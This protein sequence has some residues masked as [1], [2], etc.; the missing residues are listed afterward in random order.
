MTAQ[1]VLDRVEELGILDPKIIAELRKQVLESKY[2]V[3]PEA[4]VKVL[5]D[6]GHLT[7]Y[8]ARK[9]VADVTAEEQAAAIPVSPIPKSG[10]ASPAKTSRPPVDEDDL[11]MLDSPS[12]VVK[13]QPVPDEEEEI[14]DLE[15]ALPP[16]GP[17]KATVKPISTKSASPTG[18]P[19]PPE[20]RPAEKKTSPP[21]SAQPDDDVV[22]L[23][24]ITPAPKKQVAAKPT[25]S[26]QPFTLE[27]TAPRPVAPQP[28]PL[29][30]V[31]L[32]PIAPVTLQ[33]LAPQALQPLTPQGLQPLAP[34]VM[35]PIAPP[36]LQPLGG[37]PLAPI[38][39]GGDALFG[40]GGMDGFGAP[41][42][43][44]APEEPEKPKRAKKE[45]GRWDS[46]LMLLGGGGLGVLVIAFVGLFFAL[47]RGSSTEILDQANKAYQS[48]SYTQ[49]ADLYRKYV[50]KFPT[51]QNVS[52][53]RV[54]VGM[55][56]LRQA[57]DGA[58]DMRS[59]LK[60]ANEVL[61]TIE[62]EERFD[63]ARSELESILP[64]IADAFA[65]Q[66]KSSAEVSRMKPLV[67]N[68]HEAMKLVNNA[69]Y[70]PT[71]KRKAH[72]TK[73]DSILEK[74]RTVE[75]TINQ[76]QALAEAL[77]ALKEKLESGDIPSAYQVRQ[78]L[79][80]NYP[81]LEQHSEVVQATLS[82]AQREAQLVVTT[83]INKAGQTDDPNRAPHPQIVL[84]NRSGDTLTVPANSL[85]YQLIRGA[86]YAID[87]ATGQVRWRRHVGYE[88]RIL[89]LPLSPGGDVIVA[90][91]RYHEILRLEA[92]T[93]KAI[94]RQTFDQPF[95]MSHTLLDGFIFVST[96][97]G[98]IFRVNSEGGEVTH[99]A[100]LPQ[101][102]S[103]APAV[104][105]RRKL[106]YQL[107]E[108][109][110][111]HVLAG[112]TSS[113]EPLASKECYYLGHRRGTIAVPPSVVLG[114]AFIYENIA[115]DQ[116]QIHVLARNEENVLQPVVA[117]IPRRG[118]IVVS[119]AQASKRLVVIGDL[120]DTLVIEVEPANTAKAVNL[121]A[122]MVGGQS[123]PTLSYAA[124]DGARLLIAD[125]RLAEFDVLTT[126][127]EL[128]RK[129]S[130][131]DRDVF[132]GP[133][134]LIDRNLI[135][136]RKRFGSQSVT[137]TGANLAG[138]GTWQLEL[139]APIAAAFANPEQREFA[140][141]TSDG[142]LFEV[143]AEQLRQGV[144]DK[145]SAR[146]SGASAKTYRPCGALPAGGHLF[147]E[148]AGSD[149]LIYIPSA[150][151]HLTQ[152]HTQTPDAIQ[153]RIVPFAGGV[154]APLSSGS[155]WLLDV[156]SG[157]PLS[158]T[159]PLQPELAPGAKVE[160]LAPVIIDERQFIVVDRSRRKL[161][162]ARREEKP[163][164]Y[165]AETRNIDLDY[166][167]VSIA[168][169]GGLVLIVARGQ[170][171]DEVLAY[172]P[173]NL[174]VSQKW[175]IDGRV[176]P[177][178]LETA[179]GA[180]FC[181]AAGEFW[182]FSDKAALAWKAIIPDGELLVGPPTS[183]GSDWLVVATSGK[184]YSLN[185][186]SGDPTLMGSAR[187]PLAGQA[188][189]FG[190]RLVVGG[191]DGSLHVLPLKAEAP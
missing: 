188:Q 109:S 9:L 134:Q 146:A 170:T 157:K 123:Q 150:D 180:I 64:D 133:L 7:T 13:A 6:K 116:S 130:S 56:R 66:A 5:V 94:W 86:V 173:V 55:S 39:M 162:L 118:R 163:K 142:N 45:R 49:A 152:V 29:Q 51:E 136:V 30:P 44:L 48:G 23:E 187:E 149:W 78:Q 16:S 111:L 172:N 175:P 62:G 129:L 70:I 121:V 167:P 46:A 54:R 102:L 169:V 112:D 75:R 3:T 177:R 137:V 38:G 124:I 185:G 1:K 147:L 68:A 10:P 164:P 145:P 24:P 59:A 168:A 122:S 88:T 138:K 26:Q 81:P 115:V 135:H 65:T 37:Q 107:L 114:H 131:F 96:Q 15:A 105:T 34:Q 36:M 127:Q 90:D 95:Y 165:L 4:I 92:A 83:A 166:D 190:S 117:A 183:S 11:L 176:G 110:T 174:E 99:S 27:A 91:A 53:A 156:A 144:R 42:P 33:P 69:S 76:D 120:G 25:P 148:N 40:G 119:P 113:G 57:F 73:L 31:A 82:I 155:V 132:L 100:Q 108:H 79:L 35:Q 104:D 139:A 159:A 22:E 160:W 189:L 18:V 50:E 106:V 153:S 28:M 60:L 101:K 58:T 21:I 80:Q 126:R 178:G 97:S 19:K 93:G 182:K 8:Q 125:T 14:V 143:N 158:D 103:V 181:E 141:L 17:V 161:F 67:E 72:Q 98:K 89:P 12:S 74:I 61:P 171:N 87:A 179:G 43:P 77:K 128:D 32:Q 184:V 71:S 2:V 191:A 85:T 84:A 52:F 151:E 47:S 41:A 154:L 140:A 186:A 63:D 20:K